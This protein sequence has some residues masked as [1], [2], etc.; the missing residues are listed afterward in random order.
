MAKK[1][2][3]SSKIHPD[4]ERKPGNEDNWVEKAGGLPSYINRIA[5]HIHSDSGLSISHAIAAAVN[6]VKVLCAKGNA[7]ACAAVASW[8]KKKASTRIK[9]TDVTGRKLSDMEFAEIIEAVGYK[10]LDFINRAPGASGSNQPFDE[11][12]YLRNPGNGKFSSKFTPAEMIAGRRIVEGGITNLQV[13]QTFKL[14]GDSGW[15]K[16]SSAGYLVQGP[17]GIRVAVRTLSDAVQAAANLIAGK[18]RRV[19]EPTK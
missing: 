8:E 3:H 11:S 14:P 12:K 6:R 18:L 19:G 15:V 1:A 9:T 7:Q 10:R 13:G 5:K 2:N 4:L 16:R 17:A